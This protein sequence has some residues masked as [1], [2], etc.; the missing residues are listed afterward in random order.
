M[1]GYVLAK[2]YI[3]KCPDYTQ[4]KEKLHELLKMMGGLSQFVRSS[5]R[6]VLKPNLLTAAAPEKA[7]TTHPAIVAAMAEMAAQEGAN[8]IIADSPGSGFP[9][10]EKTMHKV[11]PLCRVT[12]VGTIVGL[13]PP[14]FY[15]FLTF[16]GRRCMVFN[17]Y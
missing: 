4:V 7:A 5:E 2:V 9:Y 12:V 17:A 6:L 15:Q 8:T 11:Y 1:G 3:V 10:N 14:D 16:H 13:F